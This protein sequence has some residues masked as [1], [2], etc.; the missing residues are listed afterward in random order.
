MDIIARREK[1]HAGRSIGTA[2]RDTFPI[3][4]SQIVSLY[5]TEPQN[6]TRQ[7]LMEI[8]GALWE[9]VLPVLHSFDLDGRLE[10]KTEDSFHDAWDP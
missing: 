6:H 5:S 7:A 3:S 10:R 4:S 8:L 9:R 1:Q 2:F